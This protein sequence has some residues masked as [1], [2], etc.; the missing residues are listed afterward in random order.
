MIT[1]FNI[2]TTGTVSPVKLEGIGS[3]HY[4]PTSNLNLLERFSLDDIVN[5][6]YIQQA[7]DNGEMTVVDQSGFT[8][9]NLNYLKP[10]VF[11]VD[12]YD[13]NASYIGYGS[14]NACNIERVTTISGSTYESKFADGS[15]NFT[16]VWADRS[17]YTYL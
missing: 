10:P 1:E 15:K 12:T 14:L 6:T 16:K 3:Y 11:E 5:D 4:H 13:T 9:T 8:I 17:T 2:T 7:I